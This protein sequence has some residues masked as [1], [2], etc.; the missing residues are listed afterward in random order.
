MSKGKRELQRRIAYEAAR[1]LTEYRSDNIA[2]ACQ[3][4]AAKLG[5]SHRQQMPTQ[6]EVEVALREQQRMFRGAEQAN[7]LQRLRQSALQAMQTLRQFNPVLVGSVFKGTA[8]SNSHVQL[9]LYA[10]TPEEVLFSLSD[11]HIPWQ[12]RQRSYNF[13]NGQRREIPIFQ[14]SA[15]DVMFELLVL[16]ADSPHTRPLDPQDNHPIQGAS[17]KQ[18]TAL[19]V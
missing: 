9:H 6:E 1:I 13:S 17:L 2:Y 16:P 15:D 7:V 19:V 3:K 11:L 18:L 10:N 14:F 4:A 8:D 5:I 12:E